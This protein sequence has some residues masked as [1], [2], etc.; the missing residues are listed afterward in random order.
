MIVLYGLL[1]YGTMAQFEVVTF[2]HLFGQAHRYSAIR[3]WGSIAFIVAVMGLGPWFD[4]QGAHTSLPWWAA[5][6]YLCGWLIAWQ[7]P[8]PQRRR[9]AVAEGGIGAV[10][11]Q[12]PVIGLLLAC[13]LAQVSFGTYYGFFSI[14]L[15]AHGY[16]GGLSS[17][18]WALGV[19]VEVCIFWW[20][21]RVLPRLSLT[22]LFLW[23]MA[24]MA[25]RWVLTVIC[26]DH[27]ILLAAVQLLHG[28]SFGLYHLSA[29]NLIQ[30][31]FPASLQGRGQAAYIGASYGLGGAIGGWLSGA[32]WDA[33]PVTWI[34]LG[35]AAMAAA[36]WAVARWGFAAGIKA[37][38]E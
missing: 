27:P 26:V 32:L 28:S 11:R 31:L 24:S 3:V 30:R 15:K 23:S 38:P 9:T 5:G 1:V 37:E 2:N 8:E 33:I 12:R 14:Y 6:M 25:L 4:Y 34:W 35:A 19:F 18:L 20:I 13:L 29:V 17:L 16:S 36:G 22:T 21:P 10:L 7:I